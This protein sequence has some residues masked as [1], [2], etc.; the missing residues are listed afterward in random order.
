MSAVSTALCRSLL[1]LGFLVPGVPLLAA[2][3]ISLVPSAGG[4][5]F[6]AQV[7]Q[8]ASAAAD[9]LGL[10]LYARAPLR[11]ADEQVQLRIIDK[12][13]GHACQVMIVAPAGPQV[14]TRVA[15]LKAA[16]IATF[17]IDRDLGGDAALAAIT[18]DNYRAGLEAG[19]QMARLLGGHGQVA[20]LRLDRRIQS[21]QERERGF[22]D[23]AR[24]GGLQIAMQ[25]TLP[26]GDLPLGSLALELGKLDGLFTPSESSTQLLLGA[27]RRGKAAG[28]LVHI[29]F[30]SNPLLIDALRAGEL[31]GLMLQQPREMGY[32]SVQQAYRYL[33]GKASAPRRSTLAAVYV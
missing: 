25:P 26:E 1:L 24:A 7:Q 12:Q 5:A 11:D 32:R 10:R 33:H 9:E 31:S 15:E 22:R 29:G 6:W 23:G 4:Q 2:D 27:L 17:Y 16:G 28:K 30:D 13:L 3:C 14:A 19:R 20:L 21:A 18:T 8:G